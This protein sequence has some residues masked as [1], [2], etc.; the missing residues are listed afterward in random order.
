M[1]C[2]TRRA[3]VYP[4]GA[5]SLQRMRGIAESTH[6]SDKTFAVDSD[7]SG[8]AT[9]AL[10]APL[11]NIYEQ[12]KKRIRAKKAI[13]AIARHLLSLMVSVYLMVSV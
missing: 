10:L 3:I 5:G 11:E 9:G 4:S 2:Q 8:L 1:V 6:K 7:G 13:I 12:Q